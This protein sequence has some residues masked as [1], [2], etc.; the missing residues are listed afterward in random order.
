MNFTRE[1]KK[2]VYIHY[3]ATSFDPERFKKPLNDYHSIKPIPDTGF[4]ASP[5]D[6]KKGWRDWAESES[7]RYYDEDNCF[8]FKMKDP[9]K[10]F[11]VDSFDAYNNLV[12]NYGIRKSDDFRLDRYNPYYIDFE[13]MVADGWDG[14]EISLSEFPPLYHLLFTWDCDS[15]LIFNSDSICEI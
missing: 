9:S 11:Y 12:G 4:W 15:I 1:G 6:A 8:K 14:L 7:F 5:I 13:K 10:I 2:V 3:G